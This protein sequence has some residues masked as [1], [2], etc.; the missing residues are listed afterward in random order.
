[1][2]FGVS[3]QALDISSLSRVE[4]YPEFRFFSITNPLG[5]NVHVSVII[6][7]ISVSFLVLDWPDWVC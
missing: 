7:E 6:R 2:V 4:V 1:M 5:C 3:G